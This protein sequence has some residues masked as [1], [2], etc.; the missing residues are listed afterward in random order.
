MSFCSL[1]NTY[2]HKNACTHTHTQAKCTSTFLIWGCSLKKMKEVKCFKLPCGKVWCRKE[3]D[4]FNILLQ[5]CFFFA[6]TQII[7][8]L[9]WKWAH[10]VNDY[11]ENVHQQ[12]DCGGRKADS[13]WQV[14]HSTDQPSGETL[15]HCQQLA[16]RGAAVTCCKTDSLGQRD[17]QYWVFEYSSDFYVP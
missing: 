15:P 16:Q 1:Y 12:A 17:C 10:S 11:I 14:P 3:V 6:R 7:P 9:L 2:T 13:V 4:F 5:S 8:L